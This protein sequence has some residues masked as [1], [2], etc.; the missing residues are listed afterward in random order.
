LQRDPARRYESAAA[1]AADLQRHLDGLPVL[2]RPRTAAVVTR[3]F[4]AR[5]RALVALAGTACMCLAA[6]VS[7]AAWQAQTARE[8]ERRA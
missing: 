4:V 2:A 6:A 7:V 5:H 3:K 1:F 8:Q